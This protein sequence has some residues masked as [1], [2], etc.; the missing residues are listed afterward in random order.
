MTDVSR[1]KENI[2]EHMAQEYPGQV[3]PVTSIR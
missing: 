2:V 1:K 3:Y